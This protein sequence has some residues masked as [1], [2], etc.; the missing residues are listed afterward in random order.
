ML[1]SWGVED[2]GGAH[3][4]GLL[5]RNN[6]QARKRLPE[7]SISVPTRRNS[8]WQYQRCWHLNVRSVVRGES[9]FII[10][11]PLSPCSSSVQSV[12][13]QAF[14]V[15]KRPGFFLLFLQLKQHTQRDWGLFCNK[16]GRERNTCFFSHNIKPN[17][18]DVQVAGFGLCERLKDTKGA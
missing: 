7:G 16:A 10:T 4:L 9:C 11:S 3:E 8:L 6:N 5:K 12:S 2:E 18:T 14:S 17:P 1:I 15:V 13:F